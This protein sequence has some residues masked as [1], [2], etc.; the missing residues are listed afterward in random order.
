MKRKILSIILAVMMLSVSLCM[1]S[2][3][4]KAPELDS[5]K[6]RFIWLIENSKEINVL[7]FGKG[8]PIYEREGMLA[9][10]LGLYY[11]DGYSSFNKVMETTRYKSTDEMKKCAEKV[12]STDYLKA[13]YE[14]AFDGYLTGSSS[15]YMRFYETSDWL[16]QSIYAP[17]YKLS[18]RIY[19]YSSI[20][21]IEPSSDEYINI[22]I[23]TYTLANRKVKTIS[24]SFVYERGNWYLDSPTY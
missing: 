1:Q 12:Y 15:A 8:L 19:D 18:E 24:L 20:R 17:D 5:V 4:G 6:E 23:D 2:C 13:I 14:T 16:Y 21:M 10:E 22:T 3:A 7:F 9:R 11:D